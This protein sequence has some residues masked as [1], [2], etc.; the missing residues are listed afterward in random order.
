META[1]FA[2]AKAA[3]M[4]ACLYSSSDIS[5]LSNLTLA[6]ETEVWYSSWTLTNSACA[7]SDSVTRGFNVPSSADTYISFAS[8]DLPKIPPSLTTVSELS[9]SISS[10]YLFCVIAPDSS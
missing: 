3:S 9:L 7:F 1:E 8:A 2:A 4:I 6:R 5:F 10:L